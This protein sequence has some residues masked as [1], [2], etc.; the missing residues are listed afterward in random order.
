VEV[1]AMASPKYSAHQ[2]EM[3]FKLIDKGGTVRAA[4]KAAGVH[5]DA[6]YRWLRQAGLS[7]QRATPRKYA[8]EQKA[9]FFRRLAL[10]PNVSAVA[11]ELGFT[12]V[13]CYAWAYKA[14]IRTSQARRVNPR[15]VEFLRLRATGLTRA[16]ARERVGADRRSATDWDKGITIINRGRVYPDGRV[17]RYPVTTLSTLTGVTPPRMSRAIG[18]RVDLDRVE[19]LIDPR[20]LSLLEREQL[21]DLHP[22]GTVDPHDRGRDGPV[23]VDDQP[24]A[25]TQHG[26]GPRVSPAHRASDLGHATVSAASAEA[27]GQC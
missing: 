7:M 20:Y 14:G 9:E 3:F 23:T 16:E 1:V 24:R 19:K 8:D 11:R 4:A 22:G 15:R 5:E 12:R 27:T 6:A 18:G 26:V 25:A 10:N 21:H 2:K 13:T 17:V